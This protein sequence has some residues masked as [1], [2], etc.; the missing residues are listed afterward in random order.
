VKPVKPLDA[1]IVYK[2]PTPEIG[3]LE[4]TRVKAGH[5]R[6]QWRLTPDEIA[7]LA[8]GGDVV[9]EMFCEPIPPVSLNVTEPFCPE[10]IAEMAMVYVDE[11]STRGDRTLPPQWRFRC[12]TCGRYA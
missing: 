10:C 9:L 7:F 5:I 11:P 2:G 4:C 3:D 8:A 12:P 1:N 6:T